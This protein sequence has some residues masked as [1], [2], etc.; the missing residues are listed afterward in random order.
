MSVTSAFNMFAMVKNSVTKNEFPVSKSAIMKPAKAPSQPPIFLSELNL[1]NSPSKIA[2]AGQK[3]AR[4]SNG[5][6]NIPAKAVTK[7]IAAIIKKAEI[8][9]LSR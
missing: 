1:N 4:K 7:I 8:L 5:L 9:S 3:I 2:L 6:P